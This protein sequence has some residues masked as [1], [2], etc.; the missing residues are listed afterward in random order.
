[1]L[2]REC[3]VYHSIVYHKL[4]WLYMFHVHVQMR[5]WKGRGTKNLATITDTHC[6]VQLRRKD[7]S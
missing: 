6:Q 1:M 3:Q 5:K 4:T 2:T 7:K